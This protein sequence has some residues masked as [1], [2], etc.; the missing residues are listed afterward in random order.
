MKLFLKPF[1]VAHANSLTAFNPAIWAQESLI[2]LEQKQVAANF[3]HRDFSNQIQAFG[4]TVHTRR[5]GKFYAKRKTTADQVSIQ[6]AS[7]TD[8]QIVLNQHLH[9]SFTIKDGE[10]S[11]AMQ[12]LVA[13]YLEPAMTAITRALD[14]IV[15]SA[16]YAGLEN[17]V[18]RLG[19]AASKASCIALD[20]KF[21]QLNVPADDPRYC[22]LT[23]TSKGDLLAET[24]FTKANEIG[25]TDAVRKAYLGELFGVN[26]MMTQLA[27]TIDAGALT[28]ITATNTNALAKGATGSFTV[29]AASGTLAAGMWV[30]AAGIPYFVTA[31]TPS[32]AITLDRPLDEAIGATDVFTF[33]TQAQIDTNTYAA[34]YAKELLYKT[35]LAQRGQLF[36]LKL[37]LQRYGALSEASFATLLLPHIPTATTVTA[38]DVIGLGPAGNWN[39]AWHPNAIA[40]VTRP[41]SAI[42]AGMGA[43]SSVASSRGFGLRVTT[44]YSILDQGIVVTIDVLAGVKVLDANLMAIMFG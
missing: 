37:D 1:K 36:N 6:D 5:P 33:V 20:T 43:R 17:H 30:T 28:L 44:G 9:T 15:L 23:P 24:S 29:G 8:V 31:C 41:L 19:T 34:G 39:M 11:L 16:A 32:T 13:T 21:N 2:V 26:Y 22:F 7:S 4:D 12:S 14:E 38:N 27:P 35:E 25:T 3:V 42:P 18:G 10:E 40:L